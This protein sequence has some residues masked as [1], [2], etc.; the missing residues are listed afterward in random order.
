MSISY[1]SMFLVFFVKLG[2]D[3]KKKFKNF[4]EEDN[5]QFDVSRSFSHHFKLGKKKRKILK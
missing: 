3:K 1:M 4:S 2:L 5:Q